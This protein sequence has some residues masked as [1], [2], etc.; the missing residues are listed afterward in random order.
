M[1]QA[2]KTI[3]ITGAASGIGRET[4]LRF[5]REGWRV[6]LCDIDAT[7]LAALAAMIGDA[8]G[9]YPA[10]VTD[11]VGLS[12]ALGAFH[13]TAGPLD[14]LFN[15]AGILDMRRFAETPL[16]RLK[17]VVDVNVGG[18]INGIHAAIPLMAAGSRIITMGSVA[19][20]YGVPDEAA[21]SASK[22]A[23]RGLTEALNIELESF[24]IWVCDIMVAYV[25]TPMV[26]D[27]PHRAQSVAILGVN[28]AS[29]QVAETVWQA[30]RLRK[31]HHF[32]TEADFGVAATVD[33]TPW[34][35][36]REIMRGIAGYSG[37]VMAFA[38]DLEHKG[39]VRSR[40]IEQKQE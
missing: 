38:S 12:T 24:G 21:Y 26:L 28:V 33:Q 19:G 34:D 29:E 18:M 35:E 32:V 1:T 30:T 20:I 27:A 4:A 25:A 5:A 10:D 3:F 40:L 22:F 11:A 13:A 9:V 23:V 7:A 2:A 14:V 8:A 39:L 31:V 17:Q 16:T 36:R 37:D 15:C 6:G